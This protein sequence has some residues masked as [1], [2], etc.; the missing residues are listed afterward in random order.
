VCEW[1]LADFF[2]IFRASGHNYTEFPTGGIAQ[3][4]MVLGWNSTCGLHLCCVVG[5]DT[6][7]EFT[8]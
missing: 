1:L 4:D 2:Q 7:S 6:G 3:L 8:D 5:V